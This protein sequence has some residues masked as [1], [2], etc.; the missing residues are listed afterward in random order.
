VAGRFYPASQDQLRSQIGRFLEGAK[1]GARGAVPKAIIAPHA[2][3]VYS[4][5]VAASAYARLLPSSDTIER[6]VLLGPS[7]RVR[8]AGLAASSARIFSTPLGDIEV[9]QEGLEELIETLPQV[10]LNDDAHREEHSLE[11]HLPFLQVVLGHFV[12]LPL[13]VGNAPAEA[14][15]EVLDKLWG[16]K[17]TLVVVSSDL[18]HFHD[19]ETATR[20]DA[21]TTEM[22]EQLR[23]AGLDGKR[24]CGASPTRGLLVAAQRRNMSVETVDVRNSGDTAGSRQEVVGYGSYLFF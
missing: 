8:L 17:E 5:P 22:I 24:A 20:V 2:G 12:L 7:H 19:Y 16:G 9:D 21:E 23:H 11:L 15:A 4:G 14:V 18:S 10:K 3:T 13:V 6:V 1:E